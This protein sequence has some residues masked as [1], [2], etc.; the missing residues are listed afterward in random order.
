MKAQF[1]SKHHRMVQWIYPLVN[2][3]FNPV[4]L[5]REASWSSWK[6]TLALREECESYLWRWVYL[7]KRKWGRKTE[8]R[9]RQ[10]AVESWG[11]VI[12]LNGDLNTK[13]ADVRPLSSHHTLLLFGFAGKVMVW[14][15]QGWSS[16][17][18]RSTLRLHSIHKVEQDFL[19]FFLFSSI[20][21][22]LSF[23]EYIHCT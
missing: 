16:S 4:I 6:Q 13:T 19:F 15:P 7:W 17:L 12:Q 22:L 10:P 20:L 8:E 2:S 5:W 18:Q 11:T 14:Q 3:I 23:L 9:G 21:P 1:R